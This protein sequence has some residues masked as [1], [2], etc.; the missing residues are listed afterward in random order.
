MPANETVRNTTVRLSCGI[1][2]IDE[3]TE[4]IVKLHIDKI[5]ATIETEK[6]PSAAKVSFLIECIS[7]P[8]HTPES[9]LALNANPAQIIS[10]ANA[11][12]KSI[13]F[14]RCRWIPFRFWLRR[15]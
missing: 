14:K 3:G 4:A 1:E 12:G 10:I 7:K 2:R 6:T 11:L 8:C 13:I 15:P 9:L 5:L